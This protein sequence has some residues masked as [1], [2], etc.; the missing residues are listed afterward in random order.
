MGT[1]ENNP[2]TWFRNIKSLHKL[3]YTEE[4]YPENTELVNHDTKRRLVLSKN[5][6]FQF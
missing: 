4:S 1:N 6:Y 2:G 5:T 3:I